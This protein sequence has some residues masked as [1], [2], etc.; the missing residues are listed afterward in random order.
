MCT[1]GPM[2]RYFIELAFSG[3]DF[4]GWQ[5]QK[6]AETVQQ[7]LDNALNVLVKDIQGSTTGCGR[8]DAGVHASQFYVHFDTLSDIPDKGDLIYRLNALL[9]PTI[10]VSRLLSVDAD[11]HARFSATS[12]TYEY[13][14]HLR[15]EPFL[16]ENSVFHPRGLDIQLLNEYAQLLA[17]ERSFESFSKV[18]TEVTNFNCRVDEAT[19]TQVSDQVVFRIRANRFLRGMVRAITGTF[20]QLQAKQEPASTVNDILEAC[21][22]SAAGPAAEPH[23]LYLTSVRYPFITDEPSHKPPI[24]LK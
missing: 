1:F 9:P 8:T 4:S 12:R 23:G 16:N 22:R 17:G 20:L 18:K 19:W 5:V 6:N 24:Q 13:Y 10:A 3:K 2:L 15:K 11:A 14:L 7:V 21:D